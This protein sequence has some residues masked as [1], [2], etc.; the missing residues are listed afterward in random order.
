MKAEPLVFLQPGYLLLRENAER[1]GDVGE[2]I[3][4]SIVPVVIVPVIENDRAIRATIVN[5]QLAQL[6]LLFDCHRRKD[7]R[8]TSP[9][10]NLSALIAPPV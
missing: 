9:K 6:A 1:L 5:K 8:E 7:D 2:F 4:K 10:G 3:L